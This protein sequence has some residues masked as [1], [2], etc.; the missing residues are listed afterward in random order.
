A[1]NMIASSQVEQL[2]KL[3]QLH[4]SQ[5]QAANAYMSYEVNKDAAEN[6]SLDEFIKVIEYKGGGN[7]Y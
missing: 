1:A 7:Q 3:R 2:Q 4:M 5:M 6:A